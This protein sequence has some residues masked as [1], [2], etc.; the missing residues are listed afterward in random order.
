MTDSYYELIDESDALGERF[1]A[2]EYVA[3]A[4]DPNVQNGAPVSALLVR[5]LERRAPR[6]D[7]RLSRVVVDLLG[8]VPI[9]DQMWV[10]AQLQRTGA[11][12]ELLSADMLAP[13]PNGSLRTVAKASGW[14]FAC[15]D[16]TELEFA[17][18][19][20]LSPLGDASRYRVDDGAPQSYLTSLDW[21][22]LTELTAMPAECWAKP[23]V[24]LVK[25]EAMTPLERLFSVADIANGL[26]TR[27][28]M[29]EWSFQNTDLVVHIH[30]APEG[31][32]IGVRAETNYGPDGVGISARTLFDRRGAIAKIQQAQLL[33]PR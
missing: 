2:S 13:G 33:R 1:G 25:G 10:F 5:A 15:H 14:R 28:T 12:I 18:D 3:G 29:G 32:W 16:S 17:V 31:E 8:P 26:G 9:S 19:P 20:P 11:K 24:D 23:H 7:A 21:C 27:I 22:S 4:W 6:E 30:R